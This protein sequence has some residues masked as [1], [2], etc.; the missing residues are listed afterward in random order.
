MFG[1]PPGDDRCYRDVHR[2][3]AA[4]RGRGSASLN[5]GN[6][7]EDVRLH[8]LGEHIDAQLAE[9]PRGMQIATEIL[10]DTTRTII[11]KVVD[12]PDIGFDWTINPYRGCEHGCIYCYARP[13][14]EYLGMSLGLDFETKIMA[15]H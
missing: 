2:T 14:H 8:V 13:T 4:A 3:G 7:F 15:K 11:N 1:S 6:R 10:H 12:S 9:H 5:P